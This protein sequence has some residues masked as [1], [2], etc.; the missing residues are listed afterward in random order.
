MGRPSWDPPCPVPCPLRPA[1]ALTHVPSKSGERVS[2]Q[3][4]L[5]AGVPIPLPIT[6]MT[7]MGGT[8][9]VVGDT[10]PE[11]PFLGGGSQSSTY[12]PKSI[13]YVAK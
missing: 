1:N 9:T 11:G 13:L 4:G 8:V 5:R 6:E 10:Q 3:R 2:A 12:Q 7:G